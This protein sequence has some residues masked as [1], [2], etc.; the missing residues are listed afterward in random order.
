MAKIDISIIITI[1][2]LLLTLIVG[3][4]ISWALLGT[5]FFALCLFFEYAT[6]IENVENKN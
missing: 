1:I 3:L 5:L 6:L 2:G 4:F